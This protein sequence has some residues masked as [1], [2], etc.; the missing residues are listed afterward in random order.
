MIR[1]SFAFSSSTFSRSVAAVALVFSAWVGNTAIA[2]PASKAQVD[3]ITAAMN[4]SLGASGVKVLSVEKVD[5]IDGLFEVVVNH[6]GSKK[7]LYTNASGS[8]M[9]LGDLMESKSMANLTEAK[10]DKLNAINFEKD[11]PIGLALKSVY[12]TGAR[13]IAV[14][15]DP[16]CG[17]CKRFRKEA[18]SKLQDTTVYTFVFPVLGKDSLDKAQKIMC[19]DNKAK[20]WDDWMMN[21]Q[22]PSGKTDCNPPINDLVA[23]GRSMGVSGTP[24]IFFQDGTRASG[25][26]PASELNRRVALASR[27]K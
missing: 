8:H 12:G 5:Y 17:Y 7:I 10:M 24:T 21:D 3:R 23:L 19:A 27:P 6:S 26:I 16:N 2:S 1:P 4:E 20:M 14:F 11:L 15:E 25:A 9:I 18:L 22:P 13:K